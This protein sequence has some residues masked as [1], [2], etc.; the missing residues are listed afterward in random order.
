MDTGIFCAKKLGLVVT[1]SERVGPS[2]CRQAIFL[3]NHFVVTAWP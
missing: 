1:S 3:R 2:A